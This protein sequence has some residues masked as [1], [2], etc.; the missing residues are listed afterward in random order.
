VLQGVD[1]RASLSLAP[2]AT[3]N[4]IVEELLTRGKLLGAGGP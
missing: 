2:A 3:D 4:Q 1:I